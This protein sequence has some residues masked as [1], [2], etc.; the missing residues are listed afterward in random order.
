MNNLQNNFSAVSDSISRYCVRYHRPREEVK[1][2]AVS[3]RHPVDKIVEFY[4]LGQTDFAENY[5]QEGLEKIQHCQAILGAQAAELRW[6]FIGHIQSRKC[7]DI[8]LNYQWV[9]TV[10]SVKVAR[11]LDQHRSGEKLNV[12]IQVN[13]DEEPNK[14]GILPSALAELAQEVS[15]LGS[16]RLRGLM[17]IPKAEEDFSVQRTAFKR[18]RALFDQLNLTG[19]QLDQLSM[20]MTNDME[21]A[22]A[23]GA[24]QLRIG[25]A[26]F[27]QRPTP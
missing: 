13:I 11:K 21:A 19:Y 20:G 24:T 2:I 23:E 5:L 26:L 14:S 15:S 17:I 1:L 12:L 22:I 10:D 4:R 8:A 9:H 18:C 7:K 25:T 16:L 3:K 27:G 6:H